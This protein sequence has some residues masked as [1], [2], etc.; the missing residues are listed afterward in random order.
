MDTEGVA[1]GPDLNHFARQNTTIAHCQ[2]S[3]V[4]LLFMVNIEIIFPQV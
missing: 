2:L 4:N 3:I 1:V